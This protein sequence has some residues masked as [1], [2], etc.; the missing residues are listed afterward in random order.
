MTLVKDLNFLNTRS[1]AKVLFNTA[2]SRDFEFLSYRE[3]HVTEKK[4]Q[5]NVNKVSVY[6]P[7]NKD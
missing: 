2:F 4:N 6:K 3:G 7:I 1:L 5:K